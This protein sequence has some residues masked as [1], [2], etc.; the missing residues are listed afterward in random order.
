MCSRKETAPQWQPPLY[1]VRPSDT[2][3]GAA[4]LAA[5]AAAASA[6]AAEPDG[7]SVGGDESGEAAS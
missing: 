6:G 7:M 1:S 4:E 5:V 3:G 2:S